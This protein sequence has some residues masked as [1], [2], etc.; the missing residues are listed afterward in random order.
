MKIIRIKKSD[1]LLSGKYTL[2]YN[3]KIK[4]IEN[5]FGKF[6]PDRTFL[7]EYDKIGGWIKDQDGNKVDMHT[8]WNI[9]KE[10]LRGHK[11]RREKW[12][13]IKNNLNSFTGL[14]RILKEFVWFVLF[15]L[16]IFIYFFVYI[17]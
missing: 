8:F 16:Y 10:R 14:V 7:I 1:Y 11:K 2:M 6:I 17:I 15:V 12:N 3:P 4:R 9:E 13:N 5:I